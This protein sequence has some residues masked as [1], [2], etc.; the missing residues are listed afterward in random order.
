[1]LEGGTLAAARL[2]GSNRTSNQPLA[3]GDT[4]VSAPILRAAAALSTGS[5]DASARD[6]P[7]SAAFTLGNRESL[8][9]TSRAFEPGAAAVVYARHAGRAPPPE[10]LVNLGWGALQGGKPADALSG[11]Y[12]GLGAAI[13]Q[14]GGKAITLGS[15]DES[16]PRDGGLPLREWSL[17]VADR[18]GIV[19]TGDVTSEMLARDRDA[20]FGLRANQK[21]ML[22]A[23]DTA[24]ADAAVSLTAIEWGDTRRAQRYGAR[25]APEIAATYRST[26]LLAADR[27]VAALLE[28]LTSRDDRLLIVAVPNLDTRQPQWAP[29]VYW[30]PGREGRG[31]LLRENGLGSQP[32]V[33]VLENLHAL[34]LS[35]LPS[36]S[37]D[38][39][40]GAEAL[41]R[42]PVEVG[43]P[44]PARRR[45]ARLMALQAGT[46]WLDAT[47]NAS[48]L[49]WSALLVAAI[50]LSLLC[51]AGAGTISAARHT[52]TRA[53][54]RLACHWARVF[55]GAVMMAPLLLWLMG[56]CLEM[57]WRFGT[58][59]GASSLSS[60]GQRPQWQ[61]VLA[62]LSAALCIL[63]VLVA[64]RGWFGKTRLHRVRIG[65]LW[66]AVTI[67][68]LLLG[69]FALPWNSLLGDSLLLQ[70]FIGTHLGDIW[71][72]LFISATLAGI[73][74]LTQAPLKTPPGAP[75]NSPAGTKRTAG[76]SR[77]NS[78]A[79]PLAEDERRAINLR[80]ANLWMIGSLA[81][82]LWGR[83]GSAIC[84]AVIA[85]G[86]MALRLGLERTPRA[87]RLNLRRLTILMV[88]ALLLIWQRG[89]AGLESALAW[90]WPHWLEQW[91]QWW[92]DLALLGTIAGA[93]LFLG[94][95]R[96]YLRDYVAVRFST[97][98]MLNAAT[99]AGLASLVI[100]G[101]M[102]PPLIAAYTL[103]AVIFEV[104]GSLGQIRSSGTT[105]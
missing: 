63:G 66:M 46:S 22:A 12:G 20:P 29:V 47:R 3:G 62:P 25:C 30:R 79:P 67:V 103:G 58:L 86:I 23:F 94:S 52:G 89:D 75:S 13:R 84:I 80:P 88:F 24:T 5:W 54:P 8:P 101:P 96:P 7:P 19:P 70:P 37:A 10:A 99:I 21:A 15:G 97:R 72:L 81:I 17:L 48:H 2:P 55:W 11:E 31:A 9:V 95:A 26:A 53:A 91:S 87:T 28:R 105:T 43:A 56:L 64:M 32:G 14:A 42:V 73:A 4:E 61:L 100:H 85:F 44:S 35:R 71:S 34:L 78:P 90:W 6:L 69:G 102:G 77:P 76:G 1:M 83:N 16:L 68:G 41:T 39:H 50:L 59:P 33:V 74:S 104:I 38:E 40:A 82:L 98:A 36:I 18:D 65:L 93:A 27:F 51:L 60:L 92:W 45:L 49:T 57:T